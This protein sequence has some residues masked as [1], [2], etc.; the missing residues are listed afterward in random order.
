MGLAG[1]VGCGGAGGGSDPKVLRVGLDPTYPPFEMQDGS[2]ALTGVSVDLAREMAAYLGRDLE[3]VPVDW[4]G[5]IPSLKSG[6]IDVILSSMTRTEE[7]ARAVL[8]SDPYAENGLCLLVAADS[9]VTSAADLDAAGRKVVVRTGTT[10]HV[11][12]R[13]N[14]EEAEVIPQELVEACLAEVVNGNVDAFI[15]DQF[16]VLEFAEKH[17]ERVRALARP[18][19]A[20]YYAM[21]MRPDDRLLADQVNAFLADFR[22]RAGFEAIVDKYPVLQRRRAQLEAAGEKFLF[23]VGGVE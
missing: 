2:G 10:G 7:R 9:P 18:I 1:L 21:A 8:F 23:E 19:Q 20:E 12:A 13:Q 16:S 3:L 17:G 11:Y 14:L 22:G 5:L 4:Q 15:Y 6:K